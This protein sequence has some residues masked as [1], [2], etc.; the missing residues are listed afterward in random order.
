MRKPLLLLP[1]FFFSCLLN[2]QD[3]SAV[4]ELKQLWKYDEAT[5]AV[6]AMI[7]EQGP[8]PELLEELADCHYQ[9]GNIA[10]ALDLY[11]ELSELLPDKVLYKLRLM[12]LLNRGQQYNAVIGIG[13]DVLQR[14]SI[15][16]VAVMVGDAFN[17]LERRDSAEWYYRRVLARRPHNE[18]VLNKL[19]NILLGQERFGEVRVLAEDFLAEEPDNLTILPI[20]GVAYFALENYNKAY[21][22]FEKVNALGD[23]SYAVHYYLGKCAQKFGI[24]DAEEREFTL[25][26]ERDSTDVGVALTVARLKGDRHAPDWE[27]WYQRALNMLLPSPKL[28]ETTGA[29]Y[30][31]YAFSSFNNERFD[32]CIQMYKKTLEY[33][34]KYYAAYYMIAQCYEYKYE[35]KTAL[36]WYQKAQ[37]VFAPNSKGREIADAG[38]ARVQAELFMIGD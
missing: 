30:Q 2:A 18:S 5:A 10:G 38:V 29:A 28:L 1:L 33:K 36:S 34:P 35:Y 27:S 37:K 14:D 26:W 16:Q 11:T 9:S 7:A 20:A 25:A 22:T 3:L 13:R 4:K 6:S 23:D 19:S 8:R 32:L 31:G 21:S 17:K 15:A 24:K 12:S